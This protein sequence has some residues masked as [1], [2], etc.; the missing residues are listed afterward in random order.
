MKVRKNLIAKE[1]NQLEWNAELAKKL[2]MMVDNP[3]HNCAK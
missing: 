1:I 3:S 2:M